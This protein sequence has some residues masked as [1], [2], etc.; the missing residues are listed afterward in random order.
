MILQQILD[1][2]IDK[3]QIS[4]LEKLFLKFKIQSEGRVFY[5]EYTYHIWSV[6]FND[7]YI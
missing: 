2:D 1:S 5:F 6:K 3:I 4:D 7:K